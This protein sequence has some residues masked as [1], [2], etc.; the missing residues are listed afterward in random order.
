MFDKLRI[1]VA[2]VAKIMDSWL[3]YNYIIC[4]YSRDYQIMLQ[5]K[6]QKDALFFQPNDNHETRVAKREKVK[7]ITGLSNS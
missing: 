4:S 6:S 1:S 7:K 2:R 3:T 5:K